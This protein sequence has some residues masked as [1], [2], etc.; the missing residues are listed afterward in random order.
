LYKPKPPQE[1]RNLAPLDNEL[2]LLEREIQESTKAE[3]DLRRVAE[4][5]EDDGSSNYANAPVDSW[6]VSLAAGSVAGA[7]TLGVTDNWLLAVIALSGTFVVAS[8]DPLEEQTPA[9]EQ[10]MLYY[11]MLLISVSGCMLSH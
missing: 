10:Y 2:L 3:L 5:L 9:G 7:V 8:G 11:N 4:I 6:Q 1:D